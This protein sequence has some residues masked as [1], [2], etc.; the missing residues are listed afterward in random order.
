MVEVDYRHS[1][2]MTLDPTPNALVLPCRSL[3]DGLRRFSESLRL[4][5]DRVFIR[6]SVRDQLAVIQ[7]L[8]EGSDSARD[9]LGQWTRKTFGAAAS[10]FART[11]TGRA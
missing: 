3:W 7:S 5:W 2:W 11:W 4:Q 10:Q 6:Y 8:R 9:V 1:G